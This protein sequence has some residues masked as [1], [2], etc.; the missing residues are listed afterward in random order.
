MTFLIGF[1]DPSGSLIPLVREAGGIGFQEL[2]FVSVESFLAQI[3]IR[4]GRGYSQ[5][6]LFTAIVW[7]LSLVQ[8]R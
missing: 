2:V 7:Q 8:L 5:Q 6:R 4:F 3:C 1:F